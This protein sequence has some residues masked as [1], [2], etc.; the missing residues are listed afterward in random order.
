MSGDIGNKTLKSILKK[1]SEKIFNNNL[2]F[3]IPHHCST[4]SDSLLKEQSISYFDY[5][6][7]TAYQRGRSNLPENCML[8]QYN[9]IGSVVSVTEK[10]QGEYGIV[11]YKIHIFNEFKTIEVKH[12]SAAGRYK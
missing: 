12:C 10:H 1:V 6:V 8:S 4:N 2:I 11:Y 7:T 5:G 3:K 9:D